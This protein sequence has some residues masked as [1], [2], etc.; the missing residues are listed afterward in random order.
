[1]ERHFEKEIEQLKET[2]I[3]MENV[4]NDNVHTALQSVLQTSAELAVKVY[5][6]E[7]EVNSF[8]IKVDNEVLNILILQH[9]V[10]IDFRAVIAIQKIANDLERIGDH[11][12][13]IAQSGERLALHHHPLILFG[14]P[15]MSEI[16]LKMLHDALKSFFTMDTVTAHGVLEQDDRVDALNKDMIREV[17]ERVK[18]HPEFL[19]VGIELIRISKNIERIADLSTNIA[20]EVMFYSEARIVKHHAEELEKK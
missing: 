3:A 9:P 6:I 7:S 8:E 11:A 14:I 4:V 20:E 1:M 12:V 15:K 16:A 5:D 17:I 2:L 19:E 18:D 13:N 10:A